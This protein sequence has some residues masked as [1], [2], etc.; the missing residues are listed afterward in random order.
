ME[1]Y[2]RFILRNR[3]GVILALIGITGASLIPI[4][5]AVLGTSLG[6]LFFGNNPEYQRYLEVSEKFGNDEVLVVAIEGIDPLAPETLSRLERIEQTIEEHPEVKQVQSMA[7]AQW[8]RVE[9]GTTLRVTKFADEVTSGDTSV[10]EIRTVIKDDPLLQGLLISERGKDTSVIIELKTNPDRP[11]E[12]GPETVNGFIQVFIDEGFSRESIHTAGMQAVLSTMMTESGYSVTRILPLSSVLLLLVVFMLFRRVWPAFVSGFNAL[13]AIVWTMGFSCAIDPQ[14]NIMLA[15]VPAVVSVVSFADVIHLC[16][17]YL[18]ELRREKNKEEAI[19]ASCA[20]VG[21]ACL[22]TSLT[23]FL[24]FIGMSFVPTPA[25]Q[26]LGLVLGF[27]TGMALLIA[28]TL[29]PVLLSYLPTPTEREEERQRNIL[30]RFADRVLDLCER[31]AIIHSWKVI[32]AFALIAGTLIAGVSQLHIETSMQDRVS[33]DN[34]LSIDNKYFKKH[35][36]TSNLLP[37]VITGSEEGAALNPEFF[38]ALNTLSQEA[39]ASPKVNKASSLVELIQTIHEPFNEGDPN[40]PAI[41]DTRE[42]L[43]QYLLLFEMEGGEELDKIIDF[44]RESV[45]ILFRLEEGKMREASA[46]AQELVERGEE[47]FPAD[48]KV[49]A[50]GQ[51]YLT[52]S[53]LDEILE[54]QK[55]GLLFTCISITAVMAIGLRSLLVGMLSMIP[56]LFPLLFLGGLLGWTQEQSDSDLLIVALLALSIGVDDTIHFLMR[57]KIEAGRTSNQTEAIRNTFTFA[58]RGILNTTVALSI[59]FLPFAISDYL[60]T[61]ILGIYLPIVFVV[62]FLADVLLLPALAQT[63]LI[64]FSPQLKPS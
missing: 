58:G 42:A 2:I 8:V 60:S 7:S 26:Q 54:G 15:V 29:V 56:N 49:E 13:L 38:A 14:I 39:E 47:L 62:A 6:Q 48:T 36:S 27:G 5:S 57:F 43:A 4:S 61:E 20:D 32:V 53:W 37:V 40:A 63:G 35:F 44:K 22:F 10:E 34:P 41:P 52:G 11:A 9:D 19:V 12:N 17:A 51:L 59:G 45:A 28:V 3:I 33:D 30:T 18:L 50:T 16:S 25:F 21:K 23:T 31:T 46:I 24:G 1:R 64:Q 55:R